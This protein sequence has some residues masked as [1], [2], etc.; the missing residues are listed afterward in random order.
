MKILSISQTR[1]ADAYTIRKEG[2]SSWDLMERAAQALFKWFLTNVDR[3]RSIYVFCGPGNNGGDGLA[4][5]RILHGAKFEVHIIIAKGQGSP[6]FERNLTLIP[7]G[8]SPIELNEFNHRFNE[9]PIIVD[10]LFGSG[11]NRVPEGLYAE[12]IVDLNRAKGLKVAIDIPSGLISDDLAATNPSLV[13]NAE[14]CLSFQYPKQGLIHPYTAHLAGQVHILD[15][16]LHP[17]Y[18]AQAPSNWH[19]ITEAEAQKAFGPRLK[20]SYKGDYGHLF[21]YCGSSRTLGAALISAE[22]ALRSGLGLLTVDLIASSFTAMNTRLPEAMLH[23]R[24]EYGDL[25]LERFQAILL[26]PGIGINKES[27]N[28]LW[29]I[30]RKTNKPMVWDADALRILANHEDWYEEIPRNSVLTPHPGEFRSLLASETLGPEQ[31]E[32]GLALA[33]EKQVHIL[34][35]GTISHLLCPD[36]TIYSYDFGSTALAKG[37]SGDLLAGL[38]AGFLA[39]GYNTKNA[40]SA[41]IYLQGHAARLASEEQGNPAAVLS[42]DIL[43]CIGKAFPK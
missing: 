5:A 27:Q 1:E 16:G 20:H 39:Q 35:K 4:L 12:C 28:Q 40:V 9:E 37:G 19:W 2:I 38:I 36:G 26:G 32:R 33:L 13:F 22:A 18:L 29:E 15:I 41:G 43:K 11:L 3:S 24:G 23:I 17:Q 42:S 31:I 30:I 14:H 10:A 21:A 8:L 7:A 34:L 25:N 6:D